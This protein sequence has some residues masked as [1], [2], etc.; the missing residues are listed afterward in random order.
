MIVILEGVDGS[1]KTTLANQLSKQT[2]YPIVHRSNPK[3]EEDKKRMMG[4]YIQLIKSNKNVIF[5]RCW[6]SEMAYGPVMRDK[7]YIDFPQMYELERMLAKNGAMIVHCTG[8]ASVLWKRCQT[9]GEDY[10]VC[11]ED[12]NAIYNRFEDIFAVP[13]YVPVVRYEYQDV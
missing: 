11:R 6:Y 1:G 4:E 3:S 8:P 12:F 13:H 7:S 2:K 5:D 10:V 9:R